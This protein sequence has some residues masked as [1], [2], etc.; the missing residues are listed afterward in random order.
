[1]NLVTKQKQIHR[2]SEQTYGYWGRWETGWDR[3]FGMDMYTL[4]YLN[5]ITNKVLCKAQET[6]LNIM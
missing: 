2:L 1:M 4:L 5:C 3:E 6:L